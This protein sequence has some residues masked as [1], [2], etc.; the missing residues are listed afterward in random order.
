MIPAPLWTEV[1]LWELVDPRDPECG[2]HAAIRLE[3]PVIDPPPP[4]EPCYEWHE[5]REETAHPG[6]L[7][8]GSVSH[9]TEE[10]I[11]NA[12]ITRVSEEGYRPGAVRR[13]C[14]QHQIDAAG[15]PVALE[16]KKGLGFY[17]DLPVGEGGSTGW[18][19]DDYDNEA[20]ERAEDILL[21]GGGIIYDDPEGGVSVEELEEAR[22]QRFLFEGGSPG[23]YPMRFELHSTEDGEVFGEHLVTVTVLP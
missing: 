17:V 8:W 2:M 9:H 13:A 1:R 14:F 18:A 3:R 23:T 5:P 16:V 4:W 21:E 20:L 10:M 11:V 22:V 15:R 6:N 12:A 7:T 19:L